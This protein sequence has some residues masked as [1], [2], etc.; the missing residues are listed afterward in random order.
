MRIAINHMDKRLK[1]TLAES[2]TVNLTGEI[3]SIFDKVINIELVYP[4]CLVAIAIDSV[5]SSPYMM[6][7][8][9][10]K[11]FSDL[12]KKINI[13]DSVCFN[14]NNSAT[15][16]IFTLDY[17]YADTWDS[18]INITPSDKNMIRNKYNH[19][20]N[21]LSDFGK[22]GGILT[23]FLMIEEDNY[24]ITPR[25]YDSYFK[26]LLD[27][28]EQKMTFD[29]L[30]QFIGLGVGLTPSGDDFITG[31]LS[32]L[33]CYAK[34][35]SKVGELFHSLKKFNFR[36]KTTHVGYYM[37]SNVLTGEINTVL[38]D[39]I[40]LEIDNK[41][42]N[43]KLIDSILNIGSTSGTDMLVGVCFGLKYLIKEKKGRT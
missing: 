34:N 8:K 7:T 12:N 27:Q 11:G 32:V 41:R 14:E 30:Q 20:K 9:E 4:S 43:E 13:G 36:N 39:Y 33:Y 29:N 19:L 15:I 25:I 2:T 42:R 37:I 22:T 1:K 17:S 23:A 28:L 38:R 10:H 5:I 6:K 24:Q 26:L 3:I 16:D 40:I 35:Q 18:S 31:L 21:Y